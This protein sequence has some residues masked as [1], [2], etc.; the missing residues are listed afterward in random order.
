MYFNLAIIIRSFHCWNQWKHHHIRLNCILLFS[1]I[2]LAYLQTFWWVLLLQLTVW[3]TG[4]DRVSV[5]F[6]HAFHW[7][8]A[9]A[10]TWQHVCIKQPLTVIGGG[11]GAAGVF[12]LAAIQHSTFLWDI[13][14][15]DLRKPAL[16][17]RS[18]SFQ[19]YSPAAASF[20]SPHLHIYH[21]L[22]QP[23]PFVFKTSG[24]TCHSH[25]W[26][27]FIFLSDWNPPTKQLS[28]F[29]FLLSQKI[30]ST[31]TVLVT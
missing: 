18:R 24:I 28:G 14:N 17:R 31:L 19:L 6:E 21:F 9:R 22:F 13:H 8:C 25:S 2:I 23:S 5:D 4:G 10:H 12:A 11:G 27:W 15:C 20:H 1:A 16:Q 3:S 26:F 29:F 7:L 30:H